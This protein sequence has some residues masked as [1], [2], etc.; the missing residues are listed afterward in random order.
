MLV[1][2]PGHHIGREGDLGA[3]D[4]RQPRSLQGGLVGLGD[5]S[6]IGYDGDVGEPVGGF[7][8]VDDRQH[9]G[10]L[11]LVALEG[12]H[13]QWEPGRGSQKTDGDLGFQAAFLGEPG[14]AEPIGGIGFEVQRRDV[15]EHQGR[16][17]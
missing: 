2:P 8:G 15:V 17:P 12:L 14:L 3:E 10:G 9:G 13:R 1:A 4:E 5:H 6:G 11:G 16:G 7:E